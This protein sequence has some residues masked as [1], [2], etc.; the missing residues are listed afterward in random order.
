MTPELLAARRI[1]RRGQVLTVLGLLAAAGV[2]VIAIYFTPVEAR[3]GLAQKI[4]YVHAPAAW[5]ALVAFARGRAGQ[6]PLPVAA[7]R[8]ARPLRRQLGR[9]RH[10]VLARH[11]HDRPDLGQADLG[12]L[13]DLGRAPHPDALPL[14]PLRRLPGAAG[15]G[16]GP[17]RAGPLQRGGGDHGP[18]AGAVHPPERLPLPHPPPPAGAAQ[19]ERAVACRRRCCGPCCSGMAAFTVLYIGFVV[20]RYGLARLDNLREGAGDAV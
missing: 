5:G 4:F 8:A 14:L 17:R 18:G 1:V 2:Y 15:R 16:A 3:Q 20:L 7:R 19:A 11:A 6:H 13:V 12:H 9:G 10:R